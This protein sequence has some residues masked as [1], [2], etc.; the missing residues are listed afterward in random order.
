LFATA[1]T[2]G[3]LLF[4]AISLTIAFAFALSAL[5]LPGFRSDL[6]HTGTYVLAAAAAIAEMYTSLS[7][8]P[9]AARAYFGLIGLLFINVAVGI[10]ARY[11]GSVLTPEARVRHRWMIISYVLVGVIAIALLMMGVMDRGG[12]RIPTVWG[13]RGAVVALPW[14]GCLLFAGFCLASIP[15]NTKLLYAPGPRRLERRL[16]GGVMAATPPII[17]WELLISGGVNPWLPLGGYF[18]SLHGLHGALLLIERFR[19]LAAGSQTVGGY[20]LE[21]RLGAGGMAEVF[22]GYRESSAGIKRRA[23]VKRLRSDCAEDPQ[24][25]RM[26]LD[27]ARLAARLHH[28]NIVGLYDAG[29]DQGEL[30]IAMEPIEGA[31]LAEVF[32]DLEARSDRLAAEAAAEVCTQLGA[33]LDYLHTLTDD[34]GRPLALVHRDVSPQNVLVD[35]NGHVKLADFGIARSADRLSRTATGVLK[36][37]VSYMAPEQIR[38]DGYDH[39][40]DLY[41]TG[42]IVF[43]LAMGRRL[44]R[45]RNEAALIEEILQGRPAVLDGMGQLPA[46]LATAIGRLLSLTPAERPMRAVELQELLSRVRQD[47]RGRNALAA[48]VEAARDARERDRAANESPT[49]VAV[50]AAGR[51]PSTSAATSDGRSRR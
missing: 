5:R 9:L 11:A 6:W 51:A 3:H 18:A 28:P 8:T 2:Y 48:A 1:Y 36:G 35:R 22:L 29:Q 26:F 33:A 25:V 41:A 12:L 23:A 49:A 13:A 14:W 7:P 17:I 19:T 15:I 47:P 31:S 38:G 46:P 21:R 24:F 10:H 43:E 34:D 30:Y 27:E 45:S 20:V 4:A 32:R 42:A 16:V 50:H 37:K 39:R 44:Y 40:V